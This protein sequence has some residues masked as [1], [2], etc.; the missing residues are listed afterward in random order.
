MRIEPGSCTFSFGPTSCSKK[1]AA[2]GVTYSWLNRTSATT[3][4]SSPGFTAGTPIFPLAGSTTQWRAR[5]FSPRVMGR[6]GVAGGERT[7]FP[8]SRATLKLNS[9]PYSMIPRVISPSPAVNALDV[10]R[11]HQL[12]SGAHLGVR[13][14]LPGRPLAPALAAHRSHEAAALHRAAGDGELVTT[15]EPQ[16]GKVAQGFVV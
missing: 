13:R 5:I 9:P 14:L 2:M 4:P 8:W 6:G 7:T 11:D 10:L 15:L 16:V 12:D 1:I 3:N